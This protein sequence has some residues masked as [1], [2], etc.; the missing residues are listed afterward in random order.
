[1]VKKGIDESRLTAKGYG[2]TV[3]VEDPKGLTGSKLNAA[4]TK[5]RRVEFK[6][7]SNLTQ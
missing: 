7:V 4:R 3:P 5:N 2:D 6:L 1:M